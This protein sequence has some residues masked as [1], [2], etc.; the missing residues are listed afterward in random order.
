MSSTLVVSEQIAAAVFVQE[1]IWNPRHPDHKNRTKIQKCWS[2]VEKDLNMNV[3]TLK[4]KWKNIRDYYRA[5][6][7]KVSSGRSGAGADEVTSSTWPL[8]PCLNYLK[9][10]METRPRTTNLTNLKSA[11]NSVENAPQDTSGDFSHLNVDENSEEEICEDDNDI[12]QSTGSIVREKPMYTS[13]ISK[14]SKTSMTK[15]R[16]EL[17]NLEAKKIKLLQNEEKDDEDLMFLKSLLPDLKSLSR[18]QKIRTKIKFQEILYNEVM[19][20]KPAT[21]TST[22]YSSTPASVSTQSSVSN[23]DSHWQPWQEINFDANNQFLNCQ[24]EPLKEQGTI[25]VDIN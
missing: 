11:S 8:F 9:D 25:Y 5:E 12:I 15:F 19:N 17:L 1:A 14:K 13:K 3:L 4:S 21:S 24:T 7:K 6:L 20:I 18:P 10:T 2:N 22:L 23:D 16:Q